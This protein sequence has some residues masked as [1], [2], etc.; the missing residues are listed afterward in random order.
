MFLG[1]A[2]NHFLISS[3]NRALKESCKKGLLHLLEIVCSYFALF[4]YRGGRF[5]LYVQEVVTLQKKH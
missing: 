4:C 5:I 2:V 1:Y 3:K